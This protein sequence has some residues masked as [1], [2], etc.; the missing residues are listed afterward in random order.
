MPVD[1]AFITVN[2][3]TI[4]YVS[5]LT[6]FFNCLDVPF[7]FSFTIVDNNSNDGSQEYIRS[8]PEIQY[9]QTGDNLGYGR[10][11]NRGTV[12]TV[13]RYVCVMNTDVILNREALVSL[14]QFMEERLEA[15]VTAPR[16]T[17]A[18]GRSQG[19][20][21]NLSLFSH[22]A[23]WFAKVLAKRSKLKMAAATTPLKV[24]GV[25][26][27]FF[28]I[29]R[30]VIP[31]PTLFDEDFFFYYEDTAL[32]HTLKNRGVSCFIIPGQKIIHIGGKSSSA[33]SVLFFYSSK[34]LYLKKFYGP[35]H[36]KTIYFMD[37]IRIFK[38]LSFYS[39]L[40][41]MTDSEHI[42]SKKRYYKAASTSGCMIAQVARHGDQNES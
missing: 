17:Y 14:W 37:R 39:L 21:F 29:R 28:L 25:M 33:G 30:S 1:I 8:H 9:L 38:K 19:M 27:A 20:V 7:S 22:Y 26:G 12:E 36:A 5:Q 11:I 2:Y 4:G 42:R 3:N 24:D 16:I 32:A 15:G 31:L 18:N 23:D 40:S 13:S 35:I 34:Y 6:D 10:A 41:L